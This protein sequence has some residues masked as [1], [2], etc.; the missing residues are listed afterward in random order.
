MAFPRPRH[1]L[2][3]LRG[4]FYWM[5]YGG[6]VRFNIFRTYFGPG[7]ELGL[8]GDGRLVISSDAGRVYFSRDC[9][10]LCSNG[11]LSIGPGVFF[12]RGCNLVAHKKIEIGAD[13][14][15]GPNVSLYDSD[16]VFADPT[17]PYRYQGY[18]KD[19]IR[20]GSNCWVGVNAVVTKGSTIGDNT[21]VGANSVVRGHLEASSLYAGQPAR[22]LRGIGASGPTT[23]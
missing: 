10:V 23:A 1:V 18:T 22:R 6:R 2:S 4:L 14:M 12:N 13:C 5:R 17:K 15:F 19:P 16:H 21:V 9:S 20:I 3:A 11:E 8:V 7:F